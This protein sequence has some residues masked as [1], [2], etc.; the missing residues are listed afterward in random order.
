MTRNKI[1]TILIVTVVFIYVIV[2]VF[3]LF[4]N[5]HRPMPPRQKTEQTQNKI[6]PVTDSGF[7][8]SNDHLIL[9]KHAKCRMDCRH[10][11]ENEL[12]EILHDGNIN[13]NKSELQNTRGPKYALEGYTSEHQHLRVIFA[14][15]IKDMIVVTCIDLDTEW[16]CPSCN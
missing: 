3:F 7:N 14:P 5:F 8:R 6:S 12:K 13:Y 9:T 10:I 2:K 16:Q 4:I 11:T 1:V 15:E